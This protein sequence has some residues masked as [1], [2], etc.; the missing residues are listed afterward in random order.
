MADTWYVRTDAEGVVI[1]VFCDDNEQPK[2]GDIQLDTNWYWGRAPGI[3]I[4]HVIHGN[5]FTVQK[6]RLVPRYDDPSEMVV[7]KKHKKCQVE[8][9]PLSPLISEKRKK[10]LSKAKEEVDTHLA[11]CI[12]TEEVRHTLLLGY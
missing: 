5:R 6:G 12:N 1:E 8:T 2:A 11:A 7:A 9:H 10:N 4:T 3:Q